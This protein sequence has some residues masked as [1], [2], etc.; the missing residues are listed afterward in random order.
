M[1]QYYQLCLPTPDYRGNVYKCGA[2]KRDNYE[3]QNAF[4]ISLGIL[5]SM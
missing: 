1:C 5:L 3:H 2:E 4:Y